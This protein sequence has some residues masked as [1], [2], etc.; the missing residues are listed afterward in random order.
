M[1]F[2][3][4]YTLLFLYVMA[5]IV[6]WGYSLTKQAGVVYTLERQTLESR[7][8]QL[9]A[10]DFEQEVKRIEEK[11]ERRRKQ[12]LGEGG[13]FLLITILASSLIYVAYYRQRRLSKV[14]QNFM[15]SITHELKTPIA[16][17]KLNMQTMEK[18]TLDA[19]NQQKLIR[20][21]ILE[22]NRLHDLCNNILLATQLE[23]SRKAFY[24]DE[25]DLVQLVQNEVDE[26][27]SR[28]PSFEFQ[29]TKG[30]QSFRFRGETMLWKLVL[31][32][33][34]ENARKYSTAVMRVEVELEQQLDQVLLRVK[35][36]GI[37]IPDAE[38]EAIFQKFYRIGSE[39]TRK[40]KG[41]GLGLYLV[42]KI[43]GL[44][45]YDI[46]VKNNYPNGSIFEIT[47]PRV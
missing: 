25:I 16:G 26:F 5:A 4:A 28:Y 27:Q 35:D 30:I 31:S 29:F 23:G 20:S 12:Y 40:T 19:D 46:V 42:K 43:I 33:L 21:T 14:Q 38:K 32:N 41:T 17:I 2:T 15:M 18:H 37:G 22:S 3:I 13:T 11:K 24:T 44:Y 10:A 39:A 7:K 1:K 6:F 45:K 8:A 36:Y 47:F 34:M 9:T